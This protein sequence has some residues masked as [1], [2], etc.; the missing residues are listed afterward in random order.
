L[1]ALLAAERE[2]AIAALEKQEARVRSTGD[3]ESLGE[4]DRQKVLYM[5][6][7]ARDAI[8]S[9]RFV[10]MVR[11]RVLRYNTQEY[12]KQLELTSRLAAPVIEPPVSGT[13]GPPPPPPEPPVRYTPAA[14]LRAEFSLP[15][16]ATEAELDQWLAAL[17]AAARAELDRGHRIIL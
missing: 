3:F 11:D 16:I 6:Q 4:T 9:A 2:R 7:A 17:R 13:D 10:S 14:R 12:P 8:Q 5:S 1:A 15:Y